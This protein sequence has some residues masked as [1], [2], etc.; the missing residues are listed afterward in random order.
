MAMNI[1]PV[2]LIGFAMAVML[3]GITFPSFAQKYKA[4]KYGYVAASEFHNLIKERGYQV[5]SAFD[6][7]SVEHQPKILATVIKEGKP[8]HLD[9]DGNE[10]P[11]YD[12]AAHLIDERER[13]LRKPYKDAERKYNELAIGRIAG[14]EKT[15]TGELY[16]L[17]RKADRKVIL[18]P[19]YQWIEAYKANFV[20][21]KKDGKYGAS[22]TTGKIFI[23]PKYDGIDPCMT[24][25]TRIDLF[26][27]SQGNLVTLVNR[28]GEEMFPPRSGRVSPYAVDGLL[29]ITSSVNGEI[30][31]GLISKEGKMLLEP[32]AR[33]FVNIPGSNFLRSEKTGSSNQLGLIT[34]QGKII[35]QPIYDYV[36]ISMAN[37]FVHFTKGGKYGLVDKNGKV[38]I[39]PF[40]DK[41]HVDSANQ[42]IISALQQKSD[43]PY[44][45][46]KYGLI[47]Y[48][49]KTIIPVSY[50]E[51]WKVDQVY[52]GLKE[53]KYLLINKSGKVLYE[54]PYRFMRYANDY[55]IAVDQNNHYGVVDLKN[56]IKIPFEHQRIDAA[57]RY[58]F[59]TEKGIYSA[60]N[61][62]VIEGSASNVTFTNNMPLRAP[63]IVVLSLGFNGLFRDRYGNQYNPKRTARN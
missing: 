46:Y 25:T 17:I 40:Y 10:Y 42:V 36:S 3:A 19:E 15:K 54:Y 9:L 16:G 44:S 43:K 58:Y 39:E 21:F 56:N 31:H 4:D 62:L 55:L 11:Y 50:E 6:T 53:G 33:D 38:V 1:Y 48:N 32:Y 34:K 13:W 51:L 45:V 52:L 20:V 8:Y 5:V 23:E 27:A 29:T 41:L 49:N 63:G 30:R 61:Q 24:D 37:G 35:L 12:V 59:A 18:K 7:V 60:E 28:K 2:K 26:S 14:Y 47:N 57:S 22:D